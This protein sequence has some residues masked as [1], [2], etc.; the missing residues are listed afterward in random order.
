[1]LIYFAAPL[2][3]QAERDFNFK[4]TT[5]LE[6]SGF[7]VFLPQRDGVE[8]SAEFLRN[9]TEKE[10]CKEIFELDRSKILES[11]IVL[12]ILEGRVPDEGLRVALGIA[13]E[14]KFLGDQEKF[15]IG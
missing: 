8:L 13:N 10:I 4:L 1:M 15:L 6:E 12:F 2:F 11:D 14:N 9:K 3:C 7:S 5:R